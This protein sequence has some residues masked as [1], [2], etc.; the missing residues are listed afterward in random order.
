MNSVILVGRLTK[1]PELRY[2]PGTGTP[3]ANFSIAVN[4]DF[5]NKEG[6]RE[7][8]FFNIVVYGKNGENCAN[9][10]SKGRLVGI[11]GSIQN[12]AY[13]T[14]AGEKRSITEIIASKVEFLESKNKS[15]DLNRAGNNFER[16]FEPTGLDPDGFQALDDD[17]IPF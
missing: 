14:Q 12:R 7:A 17:D 8:D 4:R 9:Y 2:I 1:D 6:K 10:I 16:S 15:D 13:E 11:Q 5:V 3:V